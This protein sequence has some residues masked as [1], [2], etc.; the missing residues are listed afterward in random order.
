MAGFQINDALQTVAEGCAYSRGRKLYYGSGS[1][2]C[3]VPYGSNPCYRCPNNIA[4]YVN[5]D[6]IQAKLYMKHID[7]KVFKQIAKN[8]QFEKA[9]SKAKIGSIVTVIIFVAVLLFGLTLFWW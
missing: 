9:V 4:T 5:V 8:Q 6:P 3:E 2:R 7:E 1:G